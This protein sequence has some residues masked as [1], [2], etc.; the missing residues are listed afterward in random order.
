MGCPKANSTYACSEVVWAADDDSGGQ[1]IAV[2]WTGAGNRTVVVPTAGVRDVRD[3]WRGVD[4]APLPAGGSLTVSLQGG[5][6][7]LF[8]LT[9]AH[10]G[11][12]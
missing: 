3:I 11:T 6:V 8:H 2:F 10:A 7:A 9:P 1:Y 4:L 5:D 12:A